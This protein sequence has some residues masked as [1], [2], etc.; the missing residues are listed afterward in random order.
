MNRRHPRRLPA[1]LTLVSALL[2]GLGSGMPAEAAPA[3]DDAPAACLVI[4]A[5]GEELPTSFNRWADV[6]N[7][8][9]R[10]IDRVTVQL[11]YHVDPSCRPL[12]PGAA[13]RFH[14]IATLQE[15]ILANYAYE[16][17]GP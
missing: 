4:T 1:A 12:A 13:T 17:P 6:R 16:C 8:C 11:D 10:H 3:E 7:D 2:L 14:W 15:N 9:G 5:Q